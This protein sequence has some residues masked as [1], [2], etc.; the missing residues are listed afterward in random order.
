MPGASPYVLVKKEV[1][2]MRARE[3]VPSA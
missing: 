2:E 3:S 1:E